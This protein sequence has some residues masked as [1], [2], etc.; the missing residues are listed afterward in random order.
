MCTTGNLGCVQDG[1]GCWAKR[2]VSKLMHSTL[3]IKFCF[4]GWLCVALLFGSNVREAVV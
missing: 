4:L 3:V 2:C 1:G